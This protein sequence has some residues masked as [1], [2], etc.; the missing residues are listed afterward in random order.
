MDKNQITEVLGQSVAQVTEQL[1]TLDRES[2]VEMQAQEIAGKNRSSLLAA[3]DAAL[4]ALDGGEPPV[5]P[6]ADAVPPPAEKIPLTD[7]RHPDYSGALS[8][9]QAAWR[10]HNIKPVRETRHK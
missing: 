10:V 6:E 7:Y 4:V 8:G 5:K 9:E 2:L 3:I 1:P